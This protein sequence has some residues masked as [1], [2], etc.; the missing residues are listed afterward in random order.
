MAST[1]PPRISPNIALLT[2][3][4]QSAPGLGFTLGLAEMRLY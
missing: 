3:A 2:K 1:T 4:I